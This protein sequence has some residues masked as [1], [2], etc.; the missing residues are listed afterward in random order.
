MK[1]LAVQILC[2]LLA[3][4][5]FGLNTKELVTDPAGLAV[6]E[7]KCIHLTSFE[8]LPV[9]FDTVCSV[10]SSPDLVTAAQE[11]FA[12]SISENGTVD[13]PVIETSPGRYYYINE[14]GDRTDIVELYKKQTDANSFDYIILASGQ[15]GIGYFDVVVHLQ[16]IN[17]GQSGIVY[18]AAVHAYPHS[19]FTRVSHTL[20]LT[21]SFFRK[22]MKLITWVAREVGTGLCE[23]E[24]QKQQLQTAEAAGPADG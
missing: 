2:L 22:K 1:Q 20:G 10:M 3:G 24:E 12:R 7:K 5:A 23:R 4:S 16:V 19:W 13:F 21:R 17:L 11:E 9:K 14:E 8:V 6:L 18:S 15:R